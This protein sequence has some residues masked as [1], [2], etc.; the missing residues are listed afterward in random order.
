MNVFP[1]KNELL[2]F[3]N[4]HKNDFVKISITDKDYVS[5]LTRKVNFSNT[6][7]SGISMM[8]VDNELKKVLLCSNGKQTVS[9]L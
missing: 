2:G 4:E 1:D 9:V 6:I 3:Y 7:L 8:F 5:V